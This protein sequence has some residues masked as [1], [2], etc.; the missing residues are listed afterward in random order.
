MIRSRDKKVSRVFIAKNGSLE[1][2]RGLSKHPD[3]EMVWD[4]AGHAF[5]TLLKNKDQ[6]VLEALGTS[7]MALE[8]NIDYFFWFSDL[9]KLMDSD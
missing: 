2:K 1:S 7:K 3:F 8:G 9:L 4:H 6:P 5:R